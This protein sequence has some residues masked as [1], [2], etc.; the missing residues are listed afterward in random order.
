M[1]RDRE[2]GENRGGFSEQNQHKLV[3]GAIVRVARG[4]AQVSVGGLLGLGTIGQNSA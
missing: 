4:K 2:V 1:R 3:H